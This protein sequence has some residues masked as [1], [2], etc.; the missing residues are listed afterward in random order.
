MAKMRMAGVV[1]ACG[2]LLAAGGC[3]AND[4]L[5]SGMGK[6]AS[7]RILSLDVPE[8]QA[9]TLWAGEH[10][11]T[12]SVALTDEQAQAVLRFLADNGIDDLARAQY[13]A[14]HPDEIIISDEVAQLV[15]RDQAEQF[16]AQLAQ[17]GG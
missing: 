10:T 9:L 11:D 6:V 8:V 1:L 7:G 2:V 16:L 15:T 4:P 14:Q 17:A 12:P 3:L 5:L 13:L